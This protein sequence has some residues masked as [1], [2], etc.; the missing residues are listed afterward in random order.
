MDTL[1]DL[2]EVVPLIKSQV[3]PTGGLSQSAF[4][5]NAHLAITISRQSG[6]G[7]HLVS[8]KLA[9]YFRA[10]S[11]ANARPWM[12]FDRN[13]V[14]RVLE[15]HHLPRRLGRFMPEDRVSEMEDTMSELLGGHPPSWMLARQ[16]A[17]TVLRLAEEGH[18]ILIGRGANIITRKLPHVFHVRLVG[19]VEK[20]AQ[21]LCETLKISKQA[22]L[23]LIRKEDRGR[24]RY[25]R[26]YFA[27][28]PD[29]PLLYHLVINTDFV[30]YEKAA[31]MIGEAAL[32]GLHLNPAP[33]QFD[34]QAFYR[35]EGP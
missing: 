31:V 2:E 26:K 7:A 12:I 11:P 20:R 25:L 19:S 6:C 34:T 5:N 8:E 14:D 33:F 1:V 17:E 24:Q 4:T 18:V 22:A 10:R 16:T 13:L 28:E 3:Q 27:E 30:P 35:A 15:D 23:E 21:H 29:N 9:E 32:S